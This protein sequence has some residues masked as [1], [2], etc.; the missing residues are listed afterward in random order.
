MQ[1][2]WRG[3]MIAESSDVIIENDC[4]LFPLSDVNKKFVRTADLQDS[5]STWFDVRMRSHA[6]LRAAVS[7]KNRLGYVQFIHSQISVTPTAPLQLPQAQQS[8]EL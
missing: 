5:D 4:L 6:L 1:A 3:Q 8:D 7:S 2:V